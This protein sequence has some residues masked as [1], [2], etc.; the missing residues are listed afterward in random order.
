MANMIHRRIRVNDDFDVSKVFTSKLQT[1]NVENCQKFKDV[2]L[3][4]L[5]KRIFSSW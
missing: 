3:Q 1:M 2:E 5:G 4:V